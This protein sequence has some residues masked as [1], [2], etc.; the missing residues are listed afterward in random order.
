MNLSLGYHW[1]GESPETILVDDYVYK[2]SAPVPSYSKAAM[3]TNNFVLYGK[4]KNNNIIAETREALCLHCGAHIKAKELHH[5][6]QH[7]NTLNHKHLRCWESISENEKKE[8]A[9]NWKKAVKDVNDGVVK[10][11]YLING[12]KDAAPSSTGTASKRKSITGYF[13]LTEPKRAKLDENNSEFSNVWA[14]FIALGWL[15]I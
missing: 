5:L 12:D 15:N 4:K 9:F 7:L 2:A 6:D 13:S 3:R 1:D 10:V 11:Q 8:S 14:K